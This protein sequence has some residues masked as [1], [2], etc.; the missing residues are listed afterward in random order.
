MTAKKNTVA[1][2]ARDV[3]ADLIGDNGGKPTKKT[4]A[5]AE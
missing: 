4:A 2:A 1:V 3:A 5:P